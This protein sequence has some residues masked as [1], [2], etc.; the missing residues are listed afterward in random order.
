MSFSEFTQK[1]YDL[2]AHDYEL[3]RLSAEKRC[4]NA[5]EM[6]VV[7]RTFEFANDAHRNV[8]RHSGEPYMLHPIAVA[9]IVVDDIGLGYKSIAAALLHD[10]VEDTDYTVE[11]IRELT[12][13]GIDVPGWVCMELADL[14]SVENAARELKQR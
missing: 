7:Q 2:I 6:E 12:A 11:D 9:R 5:A 4:A 10:V 1:D 14:A 13:L 3:L 8:R